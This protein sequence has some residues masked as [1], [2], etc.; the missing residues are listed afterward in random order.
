MAPRRFNAKQDM[1]IRHE[2]ENRILSRDELG[3]KHGCGG[4]AIESAIIRAGGS[5]VPKALCKN[6]F[7]V[8]YESITCFRIIASLLQIWTSFGSYRREDVCGVNLRFQENQLI[9]K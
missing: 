9:V 8:L 7:A 6:I 2:Y 5:Y 1:Q 4:S 3:I